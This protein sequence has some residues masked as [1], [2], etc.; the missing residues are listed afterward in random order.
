MHEKRAFESNARCRKQHT[1]S[2]VQS[3]VAHYQFF[4]WGVPAVKGEPQI[5]FSALCELHYVLLL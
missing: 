4:C 2:A 1:G 5:A 3:G